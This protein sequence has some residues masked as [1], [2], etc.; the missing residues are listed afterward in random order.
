V[1]LRIL[2]D[3]VQPLVESN[4]PS[5]LSDLLIY[6]MSK[7]KDARPPTAE[8][9]A[10]KLASIEAAQGWP[11][12]P[13]VIRDAAPSGTLPGERP[14]RPAPAAHEP[15]VAPQPRVPVPVPVSPPAP[16]PVVP[17]PPAPVVPIPAAPVEPPVPA[18]VAPPPVPILRAPVEPP[19]VPA[20]VAPP[21]VPIPLPPPAPPVP[22]VPIP[23][24]PTVPVVPMPPPV[25]HDLDSLRIDDEAVDEAL[26]DEAVDELTTGEPALGEPTAAEPA[27][28]EGAPEVVAAPTWAPPPREWQLPPESDGPLPSIEPPVPWHTSAPSATAAGPSA[29]ASPAMF[30]IPPAAPVDDDLRPPAPA[31]PVWVTRTPTLHQESD[32][33]HPHHLSLRSRWAAL[34]ADDTRLAYRSWLRRRELPWSAVHAIEARF[35]GSGA[36]SARGH[37]VAV[38]ERG[39]VALR[40]TRRP[41][42]EVQRLQGIL[43]AYRRRAHR[44]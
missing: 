23:A 26:A 28:D 30:P 34:D 14:L 29:G 17:I 8:E 6:A 40:A 4:V 21:P 22:V 10:G 13:F 19:P 39:T 33:D 37:L 32:H 42:A 3:P 36:R 15:L 5:P 27:P 9:F 16:V 38:T 12:T 1:I 41:R 31:V 25:P 20:P 24:A 2:R 7:D 11:R 35:G 18:P 43:D 44:L